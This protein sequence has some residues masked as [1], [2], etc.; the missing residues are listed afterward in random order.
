MATKL[1]LVVTVATRQITQN[2]MVAKSIT[3]FKMEFRDRLALVQFTK[4][5]PI[6]YNQIE[7]EIIMTEYEL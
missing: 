2:G 1:G 6:P 3:S 4:D 5:F 7:Y